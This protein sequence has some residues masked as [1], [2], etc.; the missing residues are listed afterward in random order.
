MVLMSTIKKRYLLLIPIILTVLIITFL[1]DILKKEEKKKEKVESKIIRLISEP[2]S[3]LSPT[4]SPDGKRIAFTIR[5]YN[6]S[7]VFIEIAIMELETKEIKKI[8]TL[9]DLQKVCEVENIKNFTTLEIHRLD[10]KGDKI[11][12]N[13]FCTFPVSL[14]LNCTLEA[15]PEELIKK[16]PDINKDKVIK[17]VVIKEDGSNPRVIGAGE[18]P[19][20]SQDGKK[21]VYLYKSNFLV[22][23][24]GRCGK[25]IHILELDTLESKKVYAQ[26]KTL[27]WPTFSPD[28]K[29][30]VFSRIEDEIT[31][32][33]DIYVI[34]ANGNNLKRLTS[35]ADNIYPTFTPDGKEIVFASD[36]EGGYDLYKIEIAT[37]RIE[38]ITNFNATYIANLNFSP[39][40]KKLV[41][42]MLHPNYK[43]GFDIWMMNW[44]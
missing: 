15:M 14:P 18:H 11:V 41:F 10:W 28:G 12:F 9:S 36:R 39:D 31:R 43:K 5:E 30:I 33:S 32:R 19:Y 7:G 8:F 29:K 16:A 38:K 20:F 13:T 34:D 3:E 25:E 23:V 42:S 26:D 1:T 35:Y 27:F 17:M 6:E 2:T 22:S 37:M 21:V 4:F 44:K 24:C 40:G